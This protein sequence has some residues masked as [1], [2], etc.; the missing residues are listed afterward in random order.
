MRQLLAAVA[1]P[2]FASTALLFF[3]VSFIVMIGLVFKS[4]HQE[5]WKR[6]AQLPLDPKGENHE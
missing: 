5:K 6:M 2:A 1:H 4:P 3:F